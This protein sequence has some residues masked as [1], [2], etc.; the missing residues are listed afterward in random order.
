VIAT[1]FAS[2]WIFNEFMKSGYQL[3]NYA[4]QLANHG[5]EIQRA[6]CDISFIEAGFGLQLECW[7]F[8]VWVV[9]FEI[10]LRRKKRRTNVS[11]RA[12]SAR[13]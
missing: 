7:Q 12:A 9:M 8:N 2:A 13:Q 10:E 6:V 5:A 1:T 3:S 11:L 4:A